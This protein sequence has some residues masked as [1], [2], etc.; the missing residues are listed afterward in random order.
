MSVKVPPIINCHT[1]PVKDC[2]RLIWYKGVQEISPKAYLFGSVVTSLEDLQRFKDT[3]I[4]ATILTQ[5]TNEDRA[6]ILEYKTVAANYF[7]SQAVYSQF[8]VE[9]WSHVNVTI[10][11]NLAAQFPIIGNTWD[12]TLADAVVISGL[13][14]HVNSIVVPDGTVISTDRSA[15]L[16]MNGMRLVPSSTHTIPTIWLIT[17]YF[18][19]PNTKRAKEIR[20][21]LR[22]NMACKELDRVVLLNETNLSYEWSSAKGHEKV[23]QE[24][25]GHRLTY[26]DLLKYTYEKVPPNTIVLYANADIYCNKSLTH[27]YSVSLKDQLFALLRWDEKTSPSDLH[28]FGPRPDS[29]D[30][31]IVLSDS[32][33]SRDWKGF[34]SFEYMLGT[35]GCDNRFTGDMF[36]M[37]FLV[38]NP[39]NTIQTI[40]LHNTE[41]RNYNPRAIQEAK[42]YL[43]IHPC[44]LI[45][46]PHAKEGPVK[47]EPLNARAV[48]VSLKV[49]SPKKALTF[50]TMLARENRY[51]WKSDAPNTW[52]AKPL[53]PYSWSKAFV[54]SPG[55][56]Y[57]YKNMY[58]G[59]EANTFLQKLTRN[60]E[61]SFSK[62]VVR[63]QSMMAIPCLQMGHVDL[64]CLQYLAYVLQVYSKLECVPSIFV[65]EHILP[66]IQTFTLKSGHPGKIP[67]IEWTPTTI[68]YA[69][70]VHGLLPFISEISPN[71]IEALRTAWKEY[72]AVPDASNTCVILTDDVLTESFCKGAL[73][74]LLDIYE[75]QCI[76]STASGIEAYRALN[77]A[78]LCIL[79]NNPKQ[80]ERW[81][82]LW[83]LPRTCTVL[84]F[85]S[86]LKVEG[87]FQHF[88]A[89]CGYTTHLLPLHKGPVED[90]Q[91]QILTQIQVGGINSPHTP[92]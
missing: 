24:I 43:Y 5:V 56:V 81:A 65:L 18:V 75:V 46:M 44:S 55:I 13:L 48:T 27:L 3:P 45:E 34:K 7:V 70:E 63:A 52:T 92:V 6:R 10:L 88:A 90:I 71:E 17:Q 72:K 8:P 51:T 2:K 84:E 28:L 89:A 58:M 79:L 67:A 73:Q 76:P 16:E 15:Q 69:E 14:F 80:E 42:L 64:Y 53:Q 85:Q 4:L 9:L 41:I 91:S 38:S 1:V 31:W 86:E 35:A 82:K 40:H 22:N 39:C 36:G 26:A 21:C 33:Q 11:E 57:D 60:L 19:H 59:L 74:G 30:V 66:T 50:C 61:L 12:G 87:Q 78:S 49:P 32:V 29:Q 77:G 23:H 37:R 54:T 25:L 62:P 47:R 83:T 20:Q 68:V